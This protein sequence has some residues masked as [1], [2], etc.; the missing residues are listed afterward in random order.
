MLEVHNMLSY[1]KFVPWIPGTF[2]T[3]PGSNTRFT[4]MYGNIGRID[5]TLYQLLWRL[6]SVRPI[7]LKALVCMLFSKSLEH[8]SSFFGAHKLRDHTVS[9]FTQFEGLLHVLFSTN[10]AMACRK[11]T[12][13]DDWPCV[14]FYNRW[15]RPSTPR[16]RTSAKSQLSLWLMLGLEM[17][18]WS[19]SWWKLQASTLR[20]QRE[21][22]GR[23][24][25]SLKQLYDKFYKI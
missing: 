12:E 23:Y 9:L 8:N 21:S 19:R 17:C 13:E 11:V 15:S 7:C 14:C 24:I 5:I 22:N 20:L 2:H 18:S 10:A 6:L 3:D 4:D 1:S 16:S 25:L